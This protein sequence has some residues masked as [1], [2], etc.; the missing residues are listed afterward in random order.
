MPNYHSFFTH[1]CV[2]TAQG[3]VYVW[4]VITAF[5]TTTVFCS[6]T[7]SSY[8]CNCFFLAVCAL[9]CSFFCVCNLSCFILM[10]QLFKLRFLFHWVLFSPTLAIVRFALL[11]LYSLGDIYWYAH[12]RRIKYVWICVIRFAIPWNW[13]SWCQVFFSCLRTVFLYVFH[14]LCTSGCC[15]CVYFSYCF[16]ALFCSIH[17]HSIPLVMCAFICYWRF[18]LK[19][20]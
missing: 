13:F 9:R 16:Y 14:L 7:F 19:S 1:M 11:A 2:Y 6:E 20:M 3:T 12:T 18:V 10:F 8:V 15:F 17:F 4:F 5:D